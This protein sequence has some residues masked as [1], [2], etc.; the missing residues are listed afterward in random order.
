MPSLTAYLFVAA[1]GAAGSVGRFALASLVGQALGERF[2]WGTILVN[3]SGC[4]AIGVI[5]MAITPAGRI[6]APAD[7]RQFLMIGVCGGYTTFSSFSL[8]T[9]ML[10]RAGDWIGAGANMAVSVL[11]CLLAVWAGALVGG[12]F[13]GAPGG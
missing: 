8:Q 7:V 10:L 12:L 4:F 9:L 3:I 6:Y 13:G 11:A 5:A 2:P 1:G